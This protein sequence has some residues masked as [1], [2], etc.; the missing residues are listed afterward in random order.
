MNFDSYK[1]SKKDWFLIGGAF[2]LALGLSASRPFIYSV[3]DGKRFLESHGYTE[4]TR[5]DSLYSVFGSA[6]GR[7]GFGREYGVTNHKGVRENRAVCFGMFRYQST[8]I[9]P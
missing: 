4:V 1:T 9:A 2:A 8:K 5:G 3:E 6:C 7:F